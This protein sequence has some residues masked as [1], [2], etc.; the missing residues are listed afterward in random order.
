MWNVRVRPMVVISVELSPRTG[1]SSTRTFQ[2]LSAGSTWHGPIGSGPAGRAR[3]RRACRRC[4]CPGRAGRGRGRSRSGSA[5]RRRPC[6]PASPW[7]R[8]RRCRPRPHCAEPLL[9]QVREAVPVAVLVAVP[10]AVVV[11]VGVSGQEAGP[12]V[13]RRPQAVAVRV[14][15]AVQVPSPSVS[16]LRGCVP[17]SCSRALDRPSASGS[18]DP[19]RMPSPSVSA[20]R[21]FV[22]AACSVRLVSPSRSGSSRPSAMPSRSVSLRVGLVPERWTSNAFV[23]PSW[24]LSGLAAQAEGAP[25]TTRRTTAASPAA[26]ARRRDPVAP[27]GRCRLPDVVGRG[28]RT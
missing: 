12:E 4:P 21:G 16:A 15:L 6:P 18:S 22:A 5:G 23:R 27:H 17:A 11:G 10:D 25:A 9:P 8:R 1:R 2:T 20:L 19:S 7:C 13:R 28:R 24:S 26:S 14:L 3:R